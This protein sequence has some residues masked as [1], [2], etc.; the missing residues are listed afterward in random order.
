MWLRI[1]SMF[2]KVNF[3]NVFVNSIHY[4]K[5]VYFFSVPC[6]LG[7]ILDCILINCI[8][9][10][11]CNP[12]RHTTLH[13]N[14]HSGKTSIFWLFVC[15]LWHVMLK[16]MTFLIKTLFGVVQVSFVMVLCKYFCTCITPEYYFKFGTLAFIKMS[17]ILNKG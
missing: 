17:W 9:I 4:L 16:D 11:F 7:R 10:L 14:A 2:S 3:L 8:L 1:K 15:Y 6:F 13:L 12:L 5:K